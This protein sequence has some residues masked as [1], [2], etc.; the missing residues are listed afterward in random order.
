MKHN[1]TFIPAAFA[2]YKEW[3]TTDKQFVKF[4]EKIPDKPGQAGAGSLNS[5]NSSSS[6]PKLGTNPCNLL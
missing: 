5:C 6:A 4:P 1:L 3:A 2:N